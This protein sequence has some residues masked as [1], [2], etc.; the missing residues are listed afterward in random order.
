[1]ALALWLRLS[2][3]CRVSVFLTASPPPINLV[4]PLLLPRRTC[5]AVGTELHAPTATCV[6]R[7][8]LTRSRCGRSLVRDTRR[9]CTLLSMCRKSRARNYDAS[10]HLHYR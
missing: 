3:C 9:R 7:S 5:A 8:D 2:S 4:L 1:M 6:H 10:F